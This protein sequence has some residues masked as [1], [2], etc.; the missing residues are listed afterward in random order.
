ML[1]STNFQKQKIN[2]IHGLFAKTICQKVKA[3]GSEA[4]S[5]H[6]Q[7]SEEWAKVK[8]VPSGSTKDAQQQLMH[9]KKKKSQTEHQIITAQQRTFYKKRKTKP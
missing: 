9:K 3:A 8:V 5:G 2:C 1:D 4:G 7:V 6:M